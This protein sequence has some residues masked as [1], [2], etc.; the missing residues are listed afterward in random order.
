MQL[1]S[2]IISALSVVMC[3]TVVFYIC[4][5]TEDRY[6]S[7]SQFSV[8]VDNN[9][10]GESSLGLAAL[11]GVPN[12]G[13]SDTQS[14]IGFIHSADLLLELEKELNLEAHYASPKYD[15]YYKPSYQAD[16][17]SSFYHNQL[18]SFLQ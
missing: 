13:N 16:S 11:I 8:V 14:A 1:S 3:I 2:K 12:S 18:K 7:T 17:S 10:G 15:L 4:L 5:L 9:S 6:T